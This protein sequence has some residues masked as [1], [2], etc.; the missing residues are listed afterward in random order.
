MYATYLLSGVA[1]LALA[2]SATLNMAA[3]GEPTAE[4][5]RGAM[6]GALHLSLAKK[7]T[8]S[9]EL[10]G[11]AQLP[12]SDFHVSPDRALPGSLTLN[13]IPRKLASQFPKIR[14]DNYAVLNNEEVLL[15]DP[16]TRKVVAVIKDWS[17]AGLGG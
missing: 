16:Q 14:R 15:V 8:I 12:P 3:T 4:H 13:P 5:S 9:Q 11:P 10:T 7:R 1:A 2:G 6:H 17:D